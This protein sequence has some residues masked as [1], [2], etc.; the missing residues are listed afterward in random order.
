VLDLSYYSE[1]GF[2][3]TKKLFKNALYS[4]YAIPA[5]NF[6]CLEQLLAIADACIETKSP[7]IVQTSANV[8]KSFGNA[9]TLG[10]SKAFVEIVKEKAGN[11][12]I[13]LH[14]D[15]GKTFEDC[16]SC[17]DYGY[18][19]VMIDGSDLSFD[20]NVELTKKV[21][22]Y[23]HLYDVSVEGELGALDGEN[24]TDPDEVRR[25]VGQTDVDSLAVSVGTCHG[26]NKRKNINPDG[27]VIAFDIL[28]Q[29]GEELKDFPLVLHGAS[30]I[31]PKYIATINRYGGNV[32]VYGGI[33]AD[34]LRRVVKTSVCKINVASDGWVA[35]T[36]AVREALAGN[37]EA[38][39]PRKFLSKAREEMCELYKYKINEI[40]N[41][42]GKIGE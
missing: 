23:A 36:A 28:A 40:M 42:G 7:V 15:H 1:F 32:S 37:P 14:L 38:I 34:E 6:V 27:T 24:F 41:S 19:S 20:E 13:A 35:A 25:F 39:D 18:S 4:E 31:L 11:I 33:P 8:C 22:E 2:V 30:E 17:I 16:K 26:L 21:V 5:F 10:M 29:I 3:N 9:M 12:P